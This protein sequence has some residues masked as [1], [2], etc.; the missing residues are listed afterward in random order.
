LKRLLRTGRGASLVEY[1]IL[2]GLIAVI[3]IGAVSA[4]GQQTSKAFNVPAAQ[5]DWYVV[6]ASVD[7]L[8]RYRFVAAQSP[9][10]A[11][12]IGFDEDGLSGTPYGN[13]NEISFD[14]LKV[15]SIQYNTDSEVLEVIL[16]SNTVSQ[17]PGH[18]MLCVDLSVGDEM[19]SIDFDVVTGF[20]VSGASSTFYSV[21]ASD[22]PFV[23]D[24]DLACEIT[25][26]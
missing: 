24:Q 4:L 25:E 13:L 2:V 23:I 17:T 6:G 21:S 8:A 15:R 18:E 19:F 12:V 16:F 20:Y 22:V 9:N 26:K 14:D 5:L 7:K 1:G 11:D 10:S 3:A